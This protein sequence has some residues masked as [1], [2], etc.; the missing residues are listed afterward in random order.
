MSTPPDPTIPPA[1]GNPPPPGTDP[2]APPT[3]PAPPA[4][5]AP[6]APPAGD[7]DPALGPEG[8]KALAEWKKRAKDAETLSKTQAAEL[9]TYRDRDK[10]EAERQADALKAATEQRDQARQLAVTAQVEALAAGRFQ[11]PQDAVGALQGG[12][13]LAEDGTTIDRAAITAALDTLL[14]SKPHW[15]ATG[16]LTP[17]PDPSQGPRPGGT[18]GGVDQQIADAKAKGDWRTVLSLENSKL[19]NVKN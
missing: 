17:R 6:A 1:A 16:P 18:P 13:F 12:N 4:P 5:P 3:P 19:A 14:T 9:H 10:T 7:G 15:A 8:E 2:A 11:D